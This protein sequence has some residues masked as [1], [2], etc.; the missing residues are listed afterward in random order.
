MKKIILAAILFFFISCNGKR[1]AI[2]SA[3][4]PAWDTIEM[5]VPTL[6]AR[7]A[8][9]D[10]AFI[11]A[12]ENYFNTAY[13][14]GEIIG[15]AVAIVHE[16]GLIY[17]GG[18]GK[19][20]AGTTA[21]ID[22]NTVFRIGSLSKGFTGVLGASLVEEGTLDWS[23]LIYE[24]IPEFR[25]ADSTHTRQVS[26]AHLLSH[27]SGM[28]Y[29]T[30]TNLVEANLPLRTIANQLIEVKNLQPIGEIY[31]YQNAVFALAGTYYETVKKQGLPELL[32]EKLFE[33]LGMSGASAT[34]DALLASKNIAYPHK[35]GGSN[36]WA[37]EIN[38]KYYNA[39]AAGGINASIEDMG[40][41]LYFLLGQ[42][43]DVVSPEHLS[44]VLSPQIATKDYYRYYNRWA[45]HQDSY[46]GF[47][48]RIHHFDDLEGQIDTLVHHGGYVNG[49]RSE[50]ALSQK[51][52]LGIC[53]LFN[54][55][56]A[57][58]RRCIPDILALYRERQGEKA[59]L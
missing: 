3:V 39:I 57:L 10:P 20:K 19:R 2:Q 21:E 28:P 36:W 45:G 35:G 34:Y 53:V 25:L 22:E 12:V 49:Y 32:Q 29:H 44:T 16:D 31:S 13:E 47:G 6:P 42:R 54:S 18:F 23:D 59:A 7:E 17:Q 38:H 50:I 41:W 51:E 11:T 24:R 56:T 9:T 58:S 48:W 52:E 40:K 43:P 37:Q 46:Y 26:L 14:K 5:P 1:P 55:P 15:A 30:Y 27:S 8:A 33:P 4:Y